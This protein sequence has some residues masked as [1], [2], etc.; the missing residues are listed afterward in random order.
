MQGEGADDLGLLAAHDVRLA[1]VVHQA[2]QDP[3]A[4]VEFQRML[5]EG[6]RIGR[7]GGISRLTPAMLAADHA[8]GQ[9]GEGGPIA[10]H[11]CKGLLEG[12]FA[13]QCR[14][15]LLGLA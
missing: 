4:L 2:W 12:R 14:G 5:D 15:A 13:R 11:C 8:A 3:D 7:A 1:G 10:R 6:R 9:R